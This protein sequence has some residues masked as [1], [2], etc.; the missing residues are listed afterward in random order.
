[1]LLT[2]DDGS[3][4][5]TVLLLLAEE[6]GIDEAA[7]TIMDHEIRRVIRATALL[8]RLGITMVVLF[9]ILCIW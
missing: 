2:S 6:R 7:G 5:E 4:G 9:K 1:M 3:N 8:Q